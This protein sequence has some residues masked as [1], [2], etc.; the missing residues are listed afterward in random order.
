MN[1]TSNWKFKLFALDRLAIKH[2][3]NEISS[4]CHSSCP[5]I[6]MLLK[7]AV[8]QLSFELEEQSFDFLNLFISNQ[9]LRPQKR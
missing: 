9:D 4:E 6:K 5:A 7:C 3:R 2:W 1:E 8:L